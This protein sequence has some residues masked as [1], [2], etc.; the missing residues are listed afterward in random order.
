MT[1]TAVRR[2]SSTRMRQKWL[3]RFL[4][5]VASVHVQYLGSFL[6]PPY[7]RSYLNGGEGLLKVCQGLVDLRHHCGVAVYVAQGISKEH[8]QLPAPGRS[9]IR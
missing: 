8:A 4:Q 2:R 3:G 1:W 6:G 9:T 7:A 5:N